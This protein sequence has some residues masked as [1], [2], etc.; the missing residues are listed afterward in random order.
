M[1]A[2]GNI[3]EILTFKK[4]KI[5]FVIN[6]VVN[7]VISLLIFYASIVVEDL[8]NISLVYTHL[9]STLLGALVDSILQ[10]CG[11]R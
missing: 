1:I 3:I 10:S 5:L 2:F 6:R 9:P 7:R 8:R 4:S 11:Y